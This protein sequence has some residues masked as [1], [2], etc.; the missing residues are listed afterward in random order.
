MSNGQSSQ[1]EGT[2]SLRD[3]IVDIF[4]SGS[5]KQPSTIHRHEVT[6]RNIE[7][8]SPANKTDELNETSQLL[9]D[10]ERRQSAC[11]LRECNHGT[12]SPKPEQQESS[13]LAGSYLWETRTPG[14]VASGSQTPLINGNS[15]TNRLVAQLAVKS[16]RKMYARTCYLFL[17][18]FYYGS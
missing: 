14:F 17:S 9:Q 8:E 6:E 11:G 1:P 12:F 10:Y 4:S 13:S 7:S 2:P 3:H 18:S 5:S 15:V 16:R